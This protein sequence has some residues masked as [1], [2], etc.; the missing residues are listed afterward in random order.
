[1]LKNTWNRM[2]Y[3]L[4]EACT[5]DLA[6]KKELHIFNII[7]TV[8]TLCGVVVNVFSCIYTVIYFINIYVMQC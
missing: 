4:R 1:M 6:T 3:D 5:L 2:V 8:Y 7:K